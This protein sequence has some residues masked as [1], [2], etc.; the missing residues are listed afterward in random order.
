MTSD[1]PS[2]RTAR[3]LHAKLAAGT[4]VFGPWLDIANPNVVEILSR[5]AFDFLMIDGEH[6]P[7]SPY[8]LGTLLPAAE[9]HGMPTLFRAPSQAS[10]TIKQ[11]L[12]AGVSGIMVPMVESADQ[13]RAIV[14]AARYA[15]L[16]QRGIGPWRASGFYDDGNAYFDGANDAITLILQIESRTGLENL[17]EIAAVDG[18][19]LLYVGPADMAGSLGIAQGDWDGK[20]MQVFADVARAA[21]ANGKRVGMDLSSTERRDDLM[22]LGYDFF[23]FGSGCGFLAAAADD[24]AAD[25]RQAFNTT[26]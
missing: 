11:V 21:Q 20:M 6:S 1:T 10:G 4:P 12:D 14:A 7:I 25:M 18:V 3:S 5:R 16:G 17:D 23:T 2:L 9:L 8:D 19:D 24:S 26:S 15:P 13:A 22:A